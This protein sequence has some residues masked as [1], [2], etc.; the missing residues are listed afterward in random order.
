MFICGDFTWYNCGVLIL[1]NVCET[2]SSYITRTLFLSDFIFIL[3]YVEHVIIWNLFC[4]I[5][6]QQI[7]LSAKVLAFNHYC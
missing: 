1:Y 5:K 2:L 4:T 7:Q 6:I 3:F